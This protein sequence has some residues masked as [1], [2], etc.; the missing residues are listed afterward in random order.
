MTDTATAPQTDESLDAARWDLEPLVGAEGPDGARARLDEASSRA[1]AFAERYRGALGELD[2]ASVAAA[3]RELGEIYELVGRAGTYASL[4]FSVDTLTPEVGAL[5]QEVNERSAAI[6]TSLLF[7]DLE[8]NQL[9]DE[10][11]EELLGSGE[12]EFCRHHLKTLRRYLPHQL[13]EPEERIL[14]E[15]AVTGSSAFAR[16]FTE[17][18]SAVTVELADSERAGAADGGAEPP[19]GPRSRAPRRCGGRRHRRARA[20]SADPGLSSSTRCSPT[21]RPRTGCVRIETGSPPATSPTRPP[22][23]PW[24]R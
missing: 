14:T 7:F 6:E 16:L 5:M 20:R 17:Q 2:A 15:T 19:P 23:S 1:D 18:V 8:W 10:R 12:L 11:A 4:A 9:P 24:R 22:T 21:R 13:T 3:M